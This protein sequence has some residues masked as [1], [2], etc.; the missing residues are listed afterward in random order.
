MRE[1]FT[2]QSIIILKALVLYIIAEFSDRVFPEGHQYRMGNIFIFLV[3]AILLFSKEHEKIPLNITLIFKDKKPED[4]EEDK[5][6]TKS[7]VLEI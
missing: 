6:V 1:S 3:A 5:K 2:S 4:D 7:L